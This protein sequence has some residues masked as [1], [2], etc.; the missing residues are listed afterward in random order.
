M[1]RRDRREGL[2]RPRVA[3]CVLCGALEDDAGDLAVRA[4]RSC[5]AASCDNCRDDGGVCDECHAFE[6]EPEAP[7][8]PEA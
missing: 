8:E 7:A 4:C 5:G 1:S 3:K 6:D 2:S